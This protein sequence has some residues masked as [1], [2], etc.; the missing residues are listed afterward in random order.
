MRSIE[1]FENTANLMED[2]GM[3][4][5]AVHAPPATLP[6]VQ[7]AAILVALD[8]SNQDP[9]ASALG[10]LLGDRLGAIV[11]ERSGL[12]KVRALLAA[13]ADM[14]CG[15]IVL[16]VPYGS[17]ISELREESLG[18]VMDCLLVESRLPLLAVRQPRDADYLALA[19]RNILVPLTP[20]CSHN[21]LALGWAC[22]LL[23]DGSGR[24]NMV[25]VA[26]RDVLAEARLLSETQ[27]EAAAASASLGRVLDRQF[28]SLVSVVQ[29][30]ANEAG[31][32]AIV[33]STADRFVHRAV[34]LANEGPT[35]T[36]AAGSRDHRSP[37]YHRAAD[38]ILGST[39]P[40]LIV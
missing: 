31:F 12:S 35:L 32:D 6:L 38:L 34:E 21:D 3:F 37:T 4:E 23:N 19:L 30:T 17:D 25:E 33:T 20:A 13:A 27:G 29:R 16:P 26:D 7:P 11:H 5:A 9:A 36:I 14:D 8:A 10:K 22:R 24:L 2:V 39:D 15:L 28:A 40:V 18:E 1:P